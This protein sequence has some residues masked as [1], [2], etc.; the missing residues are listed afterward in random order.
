MIFD[1]ISKFV[2]IKS[3][4][5][6]IFTR[7]CISADK[8]SVWIFTEKGQTQ[9][10]FFCSNFNPPFFPEDRQNQEKQQKIKEKIQPSGYPNMSK[11]ITYLLSPSNKKLD[12]FLPFLDI[13][14][15]KQGGVKS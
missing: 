15:Q 12:Y 5:A 11:S 14:G 7:D 10:L 13:F 9:S 8:N 6:E 4:F 3:N 1:A 2:E